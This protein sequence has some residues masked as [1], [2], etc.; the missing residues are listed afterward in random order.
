MLARMTRKSIAET[1]KK[2]MPYLRHDYGVRKISLFGSF[3]NGR[4]KR[5]SDIDL[6]VIGGIG[7]R[8]L[9]TLLS[10]VSEQIG[11]EI[12]PYVLSL[13]ELARRRAG[14]DHFVSQVLK[15]PKIFIIGTE[16]EL[17]AVV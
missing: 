10:G 9:T 1:L 12:N 15:E 13:S 8:K 14:G 6:M 17:T 4:P 3:A 7:L 2:D 16:H 11:R 5:S